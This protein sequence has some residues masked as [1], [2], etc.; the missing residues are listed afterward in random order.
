MSA[1]GAVLVVFDLD[2]T[3]WQPEMYQLYGKPRYSAL[4]DTLS[5]VEAQEAKTRKE[6]MILRDGGGSIMRVFQGA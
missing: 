4:P 5:T 2:F 1:R 3:I 6:G